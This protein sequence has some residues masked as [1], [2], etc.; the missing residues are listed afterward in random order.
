MG[1]NDALQTFSRAD[2]TRYRNKIR[3]NLDVLG[4]M[5]SEATFEA[6]SPMTG[7]EI[8]L[9]LVDPGGEPVMRN[10]AVLAEIADPDFLTEL[11]QFNIAVR[12]RLPQTEPARPL[13]RLH[14][15]HRPRDAFGTQTCTPHRLLPDTGAQFRVGKH[16]RRGAAGFCRLDLRFVKTQF[17]IF[18]HG[19]LRQFVE[20]HLVRGS[21]RVDRRG[22]S[23]LPAYGRNCG[24]GQDSGKRM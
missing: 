3:A 14:D 15:R 19:F 18:L 13:E 20:R 21:G 1:R 23:V 2:R 16:T 6:S 10:A 22:R 17:R 9:N 24:D 7:L 11:G 12:N 4:R 8:E 5:L